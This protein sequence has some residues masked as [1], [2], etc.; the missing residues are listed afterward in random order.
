MKRYITVLLF[1][2][3]STLVVTYPLIFH[4]TSYSFGKGDELLITWI[5][6][7]NIHSLLTNPL[8][9]FDAN[10]FYPYSQTLSFSEPF[11]TSSIL[12]M[13]P[14]F[15]W[16]EPMIAYN[17]NVILSL[18]LLGFAT[19]CLVFYIT[20]NVF[21]SFI[22]GLLLSFSPFTLGRLFQLQVV[23]IQWIP[24]S[25]LFFLKYLEKRRIMYL[26]LTCLF[27]LLQIANSFLPGYFL[28]LSYS[29]IV[30]H[31]FFTNR[32][33][34]LKAFTKKALF[35]AIITGVVT[36]S[37]GYPYF[38]TSQTFHYV[39]DIRD[40]IHFANRPE[41]TLYPND[42]TRLEKLLLNTVYANDKG[43]YKY[44]GYW[45]LSFISLFIFS[46]IVLIRFKKKIPYALAFLS[47]S[48]ISF[49]VSLGPAFQWGGKVLKTPFIIPLPYAL[50]YYFIP[51]F[52]GIRNSGRWEMLTVFAAAVFIGIV[53]SYI[54]RK[55]SRLFTICLIIIISVSI[56]AEINLPLK[57]VIV[58]VISQFPK[59]EQFIKSFPKNSSIIHLP[60]YSWDMQP[61]SN[62]EFMREYYSTLHFKKMVNGYS[63]F[64]PKEWEQ[65]TKLLTSK[66]PNTKTIE[67]LKSIK[68]DYVI[69]HKKDY[70][71]LFQNE[72]MVN[73]VAI[74][75]F[76]T[77]K[78]NIEL[79]P[80][81]RFVIRFDDDYV[82]QL[83]H[84]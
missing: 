78:K 11:F 67:Y 42:K 44:D 39:R 30:F 62:E 45:G 28:V 64:S 63:G 29:I 71:E 20:K 40:T 83:R 16:K 53:L 22:A 65:K 43:P 56:F 49:I 34:L 38:K 9:I 75:S 2:L 61:Y 17:T 73:K 80:E 59:V 58:P 13:I 24:M 3:I 37:L 60:I 41:Y 21:S 32:L 51:G 77:L 82:Y 7:W 15:I 46:L 1:F 6:N 12:G 66:F 69:L 18:T 84:P 19:Y 25:L 52:K 68:I 23:S 54:F 57:Y 47:I 76:E 10:I 72:Y 35:I 36:I 31:H 8:H 4:L 70:D 26:L 50:F 5:L 48:L 33:L 81:L 55:K 14:A 79:F 74:P 27:F